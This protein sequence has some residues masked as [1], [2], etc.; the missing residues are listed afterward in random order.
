MV[1]LNQLLALRRILPNK[2]KSK[3]SVVGARVNMSL[4]WRKYG[5]HRRW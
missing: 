5:L 2:N 1:K 3:T 4:G